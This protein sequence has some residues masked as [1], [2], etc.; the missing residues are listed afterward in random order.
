L[1]V[2]KSDNLTRVKGRRARER[3]TPALLLL[4][5]D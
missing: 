4:L 3:K 2:K 5:V 1:R